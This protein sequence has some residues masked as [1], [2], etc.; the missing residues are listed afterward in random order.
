MMT[1][2]NA[3]KRAT[4]YF[5]SLPPAAHLA[6]S[7]LAWVMGTGIA[8]L[9]VLTILGTNGLGEYLRLR[10]QREAMLRERDALLGETRGLEVRLD[11]LRNEPFALEKLAREQYNMRRPGEQIILLVPDPG[12]S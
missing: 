12:G 3:Q 1:D 2:R 9:A 10:Q 4:P 5:R 8:V 11:A 7:T 6:R